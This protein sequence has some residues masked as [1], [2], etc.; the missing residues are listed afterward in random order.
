MS[1]QRNSGWFAPHC[2]PL[3]EEMMVGLRLRV[4]R[5]AQTAMLRAGKDPEKLTA[6]GSRSFTFARCSRSTTTAAQLGLMAVCL[7]SRLPASVVTERHER[8][9]EAGCGRVCLLLYG[10]AAPEP[11][12]LDELHG[13]KGKPCGL[14]FLLIL[15]LLVLCAIAFDGEDAAERKERDKH[16]SEERGALGSPVDFLH[17]ASLAPNM[18]IRMR[19]TTTEAVM[20]EQNDS[21]TPRLSSHTAIK[22]GIMKPTTA[23][24]PHSALPCA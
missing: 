1:I 24:S 18:R 9:D 8:A 16:K 19:R 4:L 7:A 3:T 5:A 15:R 6:T 14:N 21:I 22:P 2:D 20:S 17:T 23:C 11:L 12:V 13:L 10:D